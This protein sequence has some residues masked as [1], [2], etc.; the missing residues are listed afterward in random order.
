MF[1]AEEEIGWEQRRVGDWRISECIPMEN[2]RDMTM[3]I[4]QDCQEALK[5]LLTKAEDLTYRGLNH[6]IKNFLTLL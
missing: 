4:R 5:I 3:E 1:C 6:W 2:V